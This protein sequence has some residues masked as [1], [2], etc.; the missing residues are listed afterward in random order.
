MKKLIFI[1]ALLCLPLPV[2]RGQETIFARYHQTSVSHSFTAVKAWSCVKAVGASTT[3]CT[4]SSGLASGDSLIMGGYWYY[5]PTASTPGTMTQWPA[6]DIGSPN[7]MGYIIT[8]IPAG[9]TSVSLATVGYNGDSHTAE[10]VSGV[11]SSTPIGPVSG[12]NYNYNPIITATGSVTTTGSGAW[13]V[14][15]FIMG[16]TSISPG[17]GYSWLEPQIECGNSVQSAG[18]YNPGVSIVGAAFY[19]GTVAFIL[20]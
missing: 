13:E 3:V 10:E 7:Y 12:I 20:N 15:G 8:G 19:Y 9:T 5:I 6:T 17:T 1:L 18:T 14:C 11:N 2:S 4:A 16:G